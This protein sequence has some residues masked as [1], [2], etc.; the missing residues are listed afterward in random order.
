MTNDIIDDGI[1][2]MF[3]PLSDDSNFSRGFRLLIVF[4]GKRDFAESIVIR[5]FLI[6]DLYIPAT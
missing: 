5:P 6:A 3:L 2:N 1:F 4:N